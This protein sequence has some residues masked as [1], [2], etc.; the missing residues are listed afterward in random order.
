MLS[1]NNNNN[2]NVNYYERFQYTFFFSVHSLL[3]S[4]KIS[5]VPRLLPLCVHTNLNLTSELTRKNPDFP[6][7]A[8]SKV[9]RA[10]MAESGNEAL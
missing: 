6:L 8:S 5:L 7:R 3:L 10:L 4:L 2:N 1:F 9:K